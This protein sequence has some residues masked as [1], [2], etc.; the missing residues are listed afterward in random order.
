MAFSN[1]LQNEI[2]GPDN[3][4]LFE[5][6]KSIFRARRIEATAWEKQGGN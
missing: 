4:K 2:K 5:S 6:F 3:R 1:S